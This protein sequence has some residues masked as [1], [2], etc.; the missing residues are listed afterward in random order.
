MFPGQGS[1]ARGMGA[2]LFDE[3]ADL[4]G[5]LGWQRDVAGGQGWPIRVLSQLKLSDQTSMCFRKE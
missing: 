3:F 4:A 1:Q 5:V 2:A